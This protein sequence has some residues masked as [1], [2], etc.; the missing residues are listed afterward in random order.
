MKLPF[1]KLFNCTAKE[2]NFNDA[3]LSDANF[4]GTDFLQSIFSNTNLFR[5]D[6]RNAYNYGIDLNSNKVKKAK[7]SL[8]DAAALLKSFDIE[9]E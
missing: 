6:F 7:F 9:V 2:A 1:L 4:K 8:P 3:D 5:A